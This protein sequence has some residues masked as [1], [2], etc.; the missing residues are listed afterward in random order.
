MRILL[1]PPNWPPLVCGIGDYTFHLSQALAAKGAEV[2]VLTRAIAAPSE[3]AKVSVHAVMNSW[4]FPRFTVAGREAER[5][6]PDIVHLQYEGYGFDQSFALPLLWRSL[7]GRRVL[8]L[9]EV[10]FKNRL[11]RLRDS[12]LHSGARH[13]IVNDQGCLE[14]FEAL[15]TGRPVT[16]IGVGAN[17]PLTE[18]KPTRGDTVQLGYFG[19]LN[20]IKALDL[21]LEAV[22]E[23]VFERGVKVRLSLAGPFD[24][25]RSREHREIKALAEKLRLSEHVQFKGQ[26]EAREVSKFLA[27]CDFAILPYTDGASPRRG[28]LQACLGMGIPTISTRS[29]FAESE[30]ID[31]KNIIYLPALSK[32]AIVQTISHLSRNHDLQEK[33]SGGA[34]MF[35]QKYRWDRIAERHIPVYENLLI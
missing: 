7:G 15:G 24:P 11:H 8:T 18:W 30:L 26:L 5:F 1:V 6:N 2:S 34:K 33:L 4:R 14:R 22:A 3:A 12:F 27:G 10:W 20:K 19:F 28:S 35:G 31:G 29:A 16:K 9:H 32:E 17:L 23:L 13:V 25:D 21:L